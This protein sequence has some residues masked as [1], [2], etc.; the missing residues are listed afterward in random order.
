[1]GEAGKRILYL[2][3]GLALVGL[4]CSRS[5]V[6][7]RGGEA[8]QILEK[9]PSILESGSFTYEE[10]VDCRRGRLMLAIFNRDEGGEEGGNFQWVVLDKNRGGRYSSETWNVILLDTARG[11]RGKGPTPDKLE[12]IKDS[13]LEPVVVLDGEEKIRAVVYKPA[14]LDL[15]AYARGDGAIR[16]EL[17]RRTVERGN[18]LYTFELK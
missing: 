16:L 9:K 3:T 12:E 13:H 7:L 10:I 17:G 8:E 5:A 4:S 15:N 14:S 1:M 18:I 2:L 6:L 11:E